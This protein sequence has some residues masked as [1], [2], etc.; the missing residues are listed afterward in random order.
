MDFEDVQELIFERIKNSAIPNVWEVAVP[1]GALMT[2]DKGYYAPYALVQFGGQSPVAMRNQGI[3]TS[4]NDVKWTSVAV[5]CVGSSQRDVRK[6]T[7]IVRDLLEGYI[8]DPSWGEL[9]ETLSGDYSV[10]VPDSDIWPVRYA[11]GIVFNGYSNAV[12]A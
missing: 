10:K 12:T 2:R 7:R 4:R 1:A 5:E 6:V 3:D 11:Q 8:P 9:T